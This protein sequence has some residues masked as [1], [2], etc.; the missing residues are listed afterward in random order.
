M[1][2]VY[3]K[4]KGRA[5]QCAQVFGYRFVRSLHVER[6]RQLTGG[7]VAHPLLYLGYLIPDM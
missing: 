4:H 6:V 3:T 5:G 2:N 1:L 7:Q